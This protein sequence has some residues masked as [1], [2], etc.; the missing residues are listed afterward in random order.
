MET[1]HRSIE[2]VIMSA[3]PQLLPQPPQPI[4]QPQPTTVAKTAVAPKAYTVQEIM[5]RQLGK[6]MHLTLPAGIV[7][8]VRSQNLSPLCPL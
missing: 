8:E 7:L 1:G 5:E 3:F 6:D 2:F 4:A